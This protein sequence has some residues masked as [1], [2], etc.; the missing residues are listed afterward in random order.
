L[1]ETILIRHGIVITMDAE[2]RI[3]EDGAVAVQDDRIVAVG[4]TDEV[5]REYKGDIVIEARKKAV[6]PG[7]VN[8][9]TIRTA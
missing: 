4:K 7:L 3:Y 1:G 6:L 9:H 2:G 8:L 5:E